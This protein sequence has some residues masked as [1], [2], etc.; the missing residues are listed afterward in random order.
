M[1]FSAA[2][3]GQS[4]G[5]I[6]VLPIKETT[7]TVNPSTVLVNAKVFPGEEEG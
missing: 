2:E 3:K 5:R 1:I 6:K 7:A 4:T